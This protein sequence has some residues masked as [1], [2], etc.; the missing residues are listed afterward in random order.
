MIETG[1]TECHLLLEERMQLAL[2]ADHP[3]AGEKTVRLLDLR[4]ETW[5]IGTETSSCRDNAVLA[6][7]RA[8]FEPRIGFESD[9]Y[10]VHQ[11]VVS[12]G[13]A[14]ALLPELLLTGRHPGMVVVDIEPDAP[15]RRVWALT[16]PEETRSAA[17]DAMVEVLRGESRRFVKAR[18]RAV[19]VAS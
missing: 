4:D 18:R 6:C 2:P 11:A 3:L 12:A 1:D 16:R 17:T 5:I 19:P 14:I 7:Q 9:D 10:Q 15:M 13:M 8:G